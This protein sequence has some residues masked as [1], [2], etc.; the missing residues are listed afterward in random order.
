MFA[1]PCPIYS[2]GHNLYKIKNISLEPVKI[3]NY[4]KENNLFTLCLTKVSS[5]QMFNQKI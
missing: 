5:G 3:A 4:F 2:Q 1:F